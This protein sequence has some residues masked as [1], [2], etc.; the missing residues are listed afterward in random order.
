MKLDQKIIKLSRKFDTQIE[1][2]ENIS[3]E[4]SK[5]VEQPMLRRQIAK[6]KKPIQGSTLKRPCLTLGLT[7]KLGDKPLSP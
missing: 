5:I 1:E 3:R 6:S 7:H 2:I 4:I